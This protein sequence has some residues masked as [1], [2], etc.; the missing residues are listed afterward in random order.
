MHKP[1][2]C[3]LV[4]LILIVGFIISLI[5]NLDT[6]PLLIQAQDQKIIQN[7]TQ[8]IFIPST[9]S[10]NA[11][12]GIRKFIPNP[13][14]VSPPQPE[15]S[16]LWNKLN[17]EREA[18]IIAK[19]NPALDIYQPNVTSN[20]IGGIDILDIKPKDW[21]D[22]GKALVYAHGGAYTQ[23]SANST[24]GAAVLVANATG[25]RV[26]SIDYTLAPFSKWNQT[27]DQV[28]SV[29][30]DLKDNHSYP[31]ENIAIFGDSAGGGLALGSVLKMRDSGIG[32]PAAIVVLSPWTD[33]SRNG[34][35]YNTLKDADPVLV[36]ASMKNF[37][38]AYA[39]SANQRNPYVSPVYGSFGEGFPPV[40][41]QIGTKEILLSDSVRLYQALDSADIPVKL[42][43]YEGMPHVFQFRLFDTPE[44]EIAISKIDEFLESYLN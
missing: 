11:Q 17:E 21:T 24:L 7:D 13:A 35:T 36:S 19:L 14:M 18:L 22:N 30:R 33:L 9:I 44:S 16:E 2:I 1:I 27:I 42:D 26:I 31:L 39:N 29:I 38:D 4:I 34:D 8:E 23:L 15:D 32:M 10:K 3:I 41:I 6:S 37:A 28:I 5:M 20:R 40:L 43:V 25:L 12:E